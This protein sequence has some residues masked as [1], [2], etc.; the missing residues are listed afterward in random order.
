MPGEV[1]ALGA[2]DLGE[3]ADVELD[4]SAVIR[5]TLR[6]TTPSTA[7]LRWQKPQM[8]QTRWQ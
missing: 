7:Q 5:V 2:E 1:T 6:R 8:A 3:L 4:G